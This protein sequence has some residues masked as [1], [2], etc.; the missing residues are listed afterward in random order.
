MFLANDSTFSIILT[1]HY[2]IRNESG[3][4]KSNTRD[5]LANQF[6]LMCDGFD[7]HPFMKSGP[8]K[9]FPSIGHGNHSNPVFHSACSSWL[10]V[11]RRINDDDL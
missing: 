11:P 8:E 9:S 2:S 5:I 10:F 4:N 6:L 7:W 3:K 1:G